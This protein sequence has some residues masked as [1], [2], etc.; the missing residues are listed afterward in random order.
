MKIICPKCQKENDHSAKLGGLIR[1][2]NCEEWFNE[3]TQT[4]SQLINCPACSL[5]VS[6]QAQNCPS[7]GQPIRLNQ[8]R[9]NFAGKIIIVILVVLAAIVFLGWTIHKINSDKRD[10]DAMSRELQDK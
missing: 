10:A 9:D 1:C 3:P 5:K 6:P 8:N 4:Q 7:C 2:A